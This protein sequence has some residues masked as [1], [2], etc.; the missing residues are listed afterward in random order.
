MPFRNIDSSKFCEFLAV[1]RGNIDNLGF[2]LMQQFSIRDIEHLCGIKAHTLRA[3]EQRYQL[4]ISDRPGGQHRVYSNDDL[5]E[6]LR[7]AYLYHQGL[8]ISS[9]AAM[10]PVEREAKLEA[11]FAAENQDEGY[12]HQL[13]EAS[14]DF[15]KDLFEKII[16]SVVLRNGIEHC[17][18]RIFYPYLHRIGLLWLTNH[19]IPAQE[20][21]ASHIIRKK[22]LVATDGLEATS[23]QQ[24]RIL[25]FA[26]AGEY[27]EIPLLTANYFFRKAGLQTIYF[28]T[29]VNAD[30]LVYYM[31]H[32]PVDYIY[33]HV[34]TFLHEMSPEAYLLDLK[35][36]FKGKI[37]RSGPA[38]SQLPAD[39]E[40]EVVLHS[41]DELIS[42]SKSLRPKPSI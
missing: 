14:L 21:F 34:I 29:N 41:L 23:L 3:W 24:P 27:H 6:W 40:K 12:I 26:P 22:L 42:F 9:I 20:H 37:I 16:N 33:T 4:G 32:H 17:V 11:S 35:Q 2:I 5:K 19:A 31:S 39:P 7:I 18:T 15:H 28:G 38:F 13:I 10:E 25:I 1:F 8:K 36:H 30:S